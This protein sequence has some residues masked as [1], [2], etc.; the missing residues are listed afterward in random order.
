MTGVFTH[1]PN[2]AFNIYTLAFLSE[3]EICHNISDLYKKLP[4]NS[5]KMISKWFLS[6]IVAYRYHTPCFESR[7]RE[8]N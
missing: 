3:I 1:I 5:I 4:K 6:T 7:Y 2:R 8:S